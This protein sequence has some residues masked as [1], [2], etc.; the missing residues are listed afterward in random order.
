YILPDA[1]GCPRSGH[2]Q[3]FRQNALS[4]SSI[5]TRPAPLPTSSAASVVLRLSCG[6]GNRDDADW[7]YL[8]DTHW[9][10]VFNRPACRS[11]FHGAVF[12]LDGGGRFARLADPTRISARVRMRLQPDRGGSGRVKPGK[13]CCEPGCSRG[14]RLWTGAGSFCHELMG[15]RSC[16]NPVTGGAQH[17]EPAVGTR[18]NFLLPA[19]H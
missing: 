5:Q 12:G 8:A 16:E 10:V 3:A 13:L 15:G 19:G 11:I 14:V 18:R 9:P 1:L 7:P 6:R 2:R 4:M 17:C